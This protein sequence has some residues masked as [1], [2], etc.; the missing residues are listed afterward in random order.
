MARPFLYT[1]TRYEIRFTAAVEKKILRR[2]ISKKQ[3]IAE[4]I[5][6]LVEQGLE[7]KAK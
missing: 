7:G 5:R 1:S 6:E 4:T 2:A 3:K